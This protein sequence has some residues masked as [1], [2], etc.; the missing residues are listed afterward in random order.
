MTVQSST[1]QIGYD[2][3]H[4]QKTYADRFG[5]VANGDYK[6]LDGSGTYDDIKKAGGGLSTGAKAGIGAGVGVGVIA[7]LAVAFFLWWRR[8]RQ[9]AKT[10]EVPVGTTSTSESAENKSNDG[11]RAGETHAH[12]GNELSG[13]EISPP[14]EMGPGIERAELGGDHTHQRFELP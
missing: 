7:L 4:Q 8:R 10:A 3:D 5:Q 12:Y 11:T 9:K 6:V 14:Q 1:I 2:K 13:K